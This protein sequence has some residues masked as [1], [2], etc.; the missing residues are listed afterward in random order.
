LTKDRWAVS[1]RRELTCDCSLKE[2]FGEL[3]D[4][5]RLMDSLHSDV[6]DSALPDDFYMSEDV[7]LKLVCADDTRV[8]ETPDHPYQ[9]SDR[10][11]G[12]IQ[13]SSFNQ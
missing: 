9:S 8:I 6:D 5:S 7:F 13:G 10:L 1:K 2:W 3:S 4:L 12:N 11:E